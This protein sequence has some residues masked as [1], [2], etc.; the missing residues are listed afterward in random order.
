[1]VHHK[2][3]HDPNS[4]SRQLLASLRTT[5]PLTVTAFEAMGALPGLHAVVDLDRRWAAIEHG[6][7]APKLYQRVDSLPE[8]DGN[9][10]LIYAGGGL[11]LLHAL[12]M[13]QRYGYRVLVFDRDE[14]GRAH[15][16]WNISDS[17]LQALVRLGIFGTEENEQ[18]V[19]HRHARGVVRFHPGT[20]QV[21]AAQL[22]MAGVLD[23]SL[24][25]AELLRCARRKFEQAGGDILDRR[26]FQGVLAGPAGVAVKI[27]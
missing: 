19:S 13:R 21:P 27:V 2:G 25:A 26:Q 5:H 7:T 4:A 22:W 20:I 14:V 16:E 18:I 6:A 23:V 15:R 10:D 11:G 24:D 1:M 9:W 17:E 8:G 3:T 12:V